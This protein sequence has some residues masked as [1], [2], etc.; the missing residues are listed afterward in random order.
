MIKTEENADITVSVAIITYNQENYISETIEGI[1]GQQTNFRFNIFIGE[2]CGSD[3][4]FDICKRYEQQNDNIHVLGGSKNLGVSKNFLRTLDACN[5]EFVA[6]C[7][8]DDYWIDR[9]KLQKQVETMRSDESLSMVFTNASKLIRGEYYPFYVNDWPPEHK[10]DLRGYLSIKFPIP[11]ATALI[12]NESVKIFVDFFRNVAHRVFHADYLLWCMVAQSGQILFL[13]QDTAVYRE[14]SSSILRST[15]SKIMLQRGLE[16]DH[17]LA[18][19]LGDEFKLRFLGNNWW[20]YLELSFIEIESR[21]WLWSIVYLY[22]A[23]WNSLVYRTISPWRLVK[24]YLFRV[25]RRIT[26]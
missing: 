9:F 18:K 7:E 4:T 23:I 26:N 19:L 22:K 21:N 20:N 14:H 11:T 13:N 12:R 2:D 16:L 10:L 5:G 8:G 25:K 3:G 1:L 17:I 24:D 15:P 6:I